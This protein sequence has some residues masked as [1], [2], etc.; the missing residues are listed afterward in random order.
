MG[1][2]LR[3]IFIIGPTASG[4][5]DVAAELARRLG[6]GVISADARQCYKYLD[7]GTAKPGPEL[8]AKAP[9]Y[10]ISELEP[11]ERETAA[12]FRRR[13]D[14]WEHQHFARHSAP[15]VYAGGSTL[16]L[17]S[18]LFDLD[19]V[20]PADSTNM[21]K[22]KQEF[23]RFGMQP[24]VERLR[25]HDPEYLERIDGPNRHRIFRALDVW[26]QTGKPF[27]SFHSRETFRA[28][29]PGSVIFM[30]D[31][32][33]D[34]LHER[35]NLRVDHM[36]EAG[37]VEEVRALLNT[38]PETLQSFQTVGYREVISFLKGE[39]SEEQM[40]ADI[41]TNTRRYAKRQLTW[42]RRWDFVQKL[43]SARATP[44]ELTDQVME[45]VSLQIQGKT[46]GS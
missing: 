36:M 22:L 41:K 16:Y 39:R 1:E 45:R 11:D 32:P 25:K 30:P 14:S 19:E 42:F 17:Q 5:S 15:M 35:I 37:L 26:M 29:R 40:V 12:V 28:P 3:R 4:K 20:P 18:V 8:L 43:D 27:S 24:L 23:E 33:R 44:A 38:W 34:Q 2:Q 13:C 6:S 7:I 9:H 46:G 21:A 31:R 10:Y